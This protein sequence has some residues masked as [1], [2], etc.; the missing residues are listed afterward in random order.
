MIIAIESL[1]PVKEGADDGAGSV[2]DSKM[3]DSFAVSEPEMES[4]PSGFPR[5]RIYSAAGAD[6]RPDD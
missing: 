2:I 5:Q 4:R 6:E 3:K 1:L